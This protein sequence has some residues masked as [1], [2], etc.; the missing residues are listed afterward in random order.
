MDEEVVTMAFR[1][2]RWKTGSS[3]WMFMVAIQGFIT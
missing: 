3:V 2:L 1:L